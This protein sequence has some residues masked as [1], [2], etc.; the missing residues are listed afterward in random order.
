VSTP[1]ALVYTRVS[2]DDQAREGL[3]LDAQVSNCR[4]YVVQHG[5]ALGQEYQDVL[6]GLKD[7]RPQYQ[8]LLE[9]V[10]RL[11]GEGKP[12]VVTVAALDRFGRSLLERARSSRELAELGVPVHSIREG[13]VVDL[14]MS[15]MLAVFA[16]QEVRR[17]GQRV[18]EVRQHTTDMGWQAVGRQAW[19]YVWRDATADER[20]M[21]APARVLDKH[22]VEAPYVREMFQRVADGGSIRQVAIW[23]RGLPP[24]AKG[25]RSLEYTSVRFALLNPVYIARDARIGD[26][27]ALEARPM[28]WPALISDDLWSAVQHR[29]AQGRVLGR[30][31]SGNFLLSGLVICPRCGA[32]M[33]GRRR[34]RVVNWRYR[35]NG[36]QS[37]RCTAEVSIRFIDEPVLAEVGTVIALATSKEFGPM[38]RKAWDGLRRESAATDDDTAKR[39]A[40]LARDVERARKRLL[41]AGTKLVDGEIDKV[42]YDALT[43]KYRA[44]QT[45]AEDEMARLRGSTSK[46]S[47]LPTYDQMRSDLGSWAEVLAGMDVLAQR[48]VIG[49][50]VQKIIPERT[51]RAQY[52]VDITWKPV[53]DA[54]RAMARAA[55][56]A[57]S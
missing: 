20:T 9:D 54:L 23:V 24:E 45:A 15:D 35:C 44:D 33:V 14:V 2:S 25:G 7:Q 53:G 29:L 10:R 48:D 47:V 12:V 31:A 43:H 41:D 57:A 6:S 40:T 8:Q 19:G 3:S 36:F 52:R 13:G 51:G 37:G 16:E 18:R 11:R 22:E 26:D 49:E 32:R 34:P 27:D 4:K 30:Q 1:L 46:Q 42:M 39:L 21:G 56:A 50:L 38:V 5:W 17:L 55:R 28:R